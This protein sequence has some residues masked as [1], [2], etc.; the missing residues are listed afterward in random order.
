MVIKVVNLVKRYGER[1]VLDH[2]NLEISEGEIYGLLGSGGSGKTSA[3]NCI[4]SLLKY[5]KGIVQILEQT[6]HVYS[7]DLKK[8]IGI[9]MQ[10]TAV[11]DEL[12]VHENIDYF[13]SLYEKQKWS[14]K[15]MVEEAIEFCGLAQFRDFYPRKLNRDILKRLNLACGIAHKPQILIWDE[16]F[17]G[18]DIQSRRQM[19]DMIKVLNK[20]GMSI[21]Y[22]SQSMEEGEELCTKIGL[23]DKGKVIAAGTPEELKAMIGSGEKVTI[24][25]FYL[26]K[27]DLQGIKKMPNVSYATYI[28]NTLA[29]KSEG[30]NNLVMILHYLEEHGILFGKIHS[31]LP[32]LK[33]VYCEMTG[34]E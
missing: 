33:D 15:E 26:E 14:R 4:L 8:K 28:G 6:M 17:I 11:F 9:V 5:D 31:E 21:L 20:K 24:E 25:V 22:T 13:C 10:N 7:D 2:F 12:T 32:G 30:R 3:V 23:L 34:K 18:L 1:I 27:E 16:P 19:K 29:V